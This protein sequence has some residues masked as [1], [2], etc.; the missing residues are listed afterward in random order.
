MTLN[1]VEDLEQYGVGG[2]MKYRK[3]KTKTGMMSWTEWEDCWSAFAHLY[4]KFHKAE[5][6]LLPEK[7][8]KHKK[9]VKGLKKLG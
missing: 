2:V 8:A 6:P 5:D 4:N 9:A 1:E 7:L 3:K